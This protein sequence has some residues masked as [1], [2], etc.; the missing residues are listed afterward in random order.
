VRPKQYWRQQLKPGR[1]VPDSDL[2][3]LS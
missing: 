2:L 1:F 3:Q